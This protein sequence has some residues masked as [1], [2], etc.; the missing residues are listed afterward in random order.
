M[1]AKVKRL[2]IYGGTFNPIHHGHLILAR[3]AM[4]LLELHRLLVVPNARSPLRLGEALTPA[5]LRLELVRLALEG[6]PGMEACDLEIRRGGS[7]YTVETLE[8]LSEQYPDMELIFLAGADSLDTLDRWVRVEQ[9]V[10]LARVVILPRP[11]YSRTRALRELLLRAPHMAGKVE[12]LETARR[13]DISSTEIR[14]RMAAGRSIRW[15]VP[16]AVAA[17]LC[18]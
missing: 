4:E 16:D 5:D 12:M 17:A 2:G 8:T 10:Q 6:E 18:R 11:G 15:L 7:S 14:E 13:V 9:I 3:E 1:N